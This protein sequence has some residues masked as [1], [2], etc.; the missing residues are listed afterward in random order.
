[1]AGCPLIALNGSSITEVAGDAGYL[2]KD[3][4]F[5]EFQN[6]V[7]Y[8]DENRFSL[9]EKELNQALLF[10]LDKCYKKTFEIYQELYNK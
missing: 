6:G 1:M 8:I 5:A 10:S 9:I 3:L 7:I 2:M 4:S